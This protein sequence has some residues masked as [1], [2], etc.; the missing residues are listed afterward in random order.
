MNVFVGPKVLYKMFVNQSLSQ[1]F[2]NDLFVFLI[3]FKVKDI[4]L[5]LCNR[6]CV[7]V[8]YVHVL[9]AFSLSPTGSVSLVIMFFVK[10]FTSLLR[11][12]CPC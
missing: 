7:S 8:K 3:V 12:V 9:C 11:T 2:I 10:S 4:E 6:K 5:I 1:S